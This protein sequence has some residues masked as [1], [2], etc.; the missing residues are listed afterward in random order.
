MLLQGFRH[1]TIS[2]P[3]GEAPELPQPTQPLLCKNS[4]ALKWQ[5]PVPDA[6]RA[7]VAGVLS[8]LVQLPQLCRAVH[9]RLGASRLSALLAAAMKAIA[10]GGGGG[11]LD[12]F[13]NGSVLVQ[14]CA[15]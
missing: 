3:A 13:C 11:C 10:E 6:T 8:E 12:L 14:K 5:G 15:L 1:L 4:T 7:A 2:C 9:D